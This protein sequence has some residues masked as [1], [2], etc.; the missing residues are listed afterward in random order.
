M[1]EAGKITTRIPFGSLSFPNMYKKSLLR[2]SAEQG[3][4]KHAQ[5]KFSIVFTIY[6]IYDVCVEF[7]VFSLT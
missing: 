2:I 5:Y 6:M 1:I 4:A 3:S 7:C